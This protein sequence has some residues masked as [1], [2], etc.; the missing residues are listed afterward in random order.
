MTSDDAPQIHIDSDWKAE[1]QAEKERLAAAEKEKEAVASSDSPKLPPA[2]FQG[3]VGI[4]ASQAVMGL[5]AVPD[6]SGK[7]VLIDLDGA[8]F[9]IDLL[10]VLEE[11]TAGNLT[12]DEAKE[13]GVVLTELRAR[14]VQVTQ[15][16]AQQMAQPTAGGEAGA[17][18]GIVMPD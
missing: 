9:A 18:P 1:A 7:G 2:N 5:G 15:L 14:F 17:G 12:E 11:K 13:I 6:E 3:L 16:I 4:L 10:T 8:K